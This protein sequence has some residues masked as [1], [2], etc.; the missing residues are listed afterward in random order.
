MVDVKRMF[1]LNDEYLTEVWIADQ[2]L[3]N[4]VKIMGHA[5]AK[6]FGNKLR[7][8]AKQGFQTGHDA[9]DI[10]PRKNGKVFRIGAEWTKFRLLGFYEGPL[11]TKFI[12]I[13]GYKG[14]GQVQDNNAT[15]EVERIRKLGDWRE[16]T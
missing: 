3:A 2:A 15:I 13:K 11:N 7:A 4:T 8:Y 1:P 16:V 12:T 6:R 14:G 9:R 5:D 10:R